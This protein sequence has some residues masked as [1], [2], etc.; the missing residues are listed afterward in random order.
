MRRPQSAI[1]LA[2]VM[3]SLFVM[4][5]T[6]ATAQAAPS[7]A[8]PN[9]CT[10]HSS[11]KRP[12]A[13][14]RVLRSKR[15]Q[16]PN[17]VAGTVQEVE[18]RD[19]VG[20]VM[21]AEWP[22]HYPIET[23]KAGAI[24]VK[25]YGWY[26]T[27]QYR[28][29]TRKVDGKQV[30]YDVRDDTNDQVYYPER[31]T[32][33]NKV[34]RAI[35]LTWDIT[36]RKFKFA[37]QS[38]KFFLTGYRAGSSSTCGAE[39]TGYKLFQHGARDCGVKGLKY[40]EILRTYLKPRL[41]IVQNG[42]HD[43]VGTDRGDAAAL[44][45]AGGKLVPHVWP[46]GK[47]SGSGSNAGISISP[48]DVVGLRASDVNRDGRDDLVWLRKTGATSG[49]VRVALSDGSDYLEPTT[50]FDGDIGVPL[51]DARFL[52]GDFDADHK[53]DVAVLGRG[54]SA[55]TGRLR[56][57]YKDGSAFKPPV[58]VWA[59][60]VDLARVHTVWGGD[61]S[62][63][64]RADLMVRERVDGGG[65]RVRIAR[66]EGSGSLGNLKTRFL[67]TAF[68]S[69]ETR[70]VAGDANRDGREDLLMLVGI[71]SRTKVQRLEGKPSGALGYVKFWKA[72]KN[73]PVPVGNTHIGGADV[74]ADGRIDLVLFTKDGSGTRMRVL[75]T[76][77]TTMVAG[78]DSDLNGL[79]WADTRPY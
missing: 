46:K 36:L 51:A 43:I 18:F 2:V 40:R 31:W 34:D 63:D 6:P 25:Q 55:G 64:G 62:G 15:S 66:N 1:G 47:P 65:V 45:T 26:Y 75:K 77:Y 68:N 27:R 56:V 23:L 14:I 73:D 11:E 21:M 3:A 24:A 71:G 32:A 72:P 39:T 33:T 54:T 79:V 61:I 10:G 38:S 67:S 8:A 35:D 44:V 69:S 16:T 48:V 57:L 28:G 59:G 17:S 70:M 22:D 42:R 5:L 74:D 78:S 49:R 30:C 20:V 52:V 76:R 4:T 29:K 13:T 9:E 7:P 58:T 41:E 60:S 19:Y 53:R 37:T 50:W 12:P